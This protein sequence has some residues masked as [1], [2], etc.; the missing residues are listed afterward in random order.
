MTAA[1]DLS[2]DGHPYAGR[3]EDGLWVFAGFG[4]H[5]TMHGP[6]LAE[7]LVRA[8]RSADEGEL[9]LFNPKRTGPPAHEEWLVASRK[10]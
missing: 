1:A 6:V 5:G 10:A 2:V 4:G 8:I 7:D 9:A 3:L